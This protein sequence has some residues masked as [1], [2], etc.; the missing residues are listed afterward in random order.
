MTPKKVEYPSVREI[1]ITR[2]VD[3]PRE[4]V[5]KAWTTPENIAVWWGPRGFTTRVEEHDLRP[6]GR[7]H[8]VMVAPDGEEYPAM[9]TFREVVP[10]ERI[11]TTDEFGEDFEHDMDLP[12]G[13]VF[14]CL[15]EEV[16]EKTRLTLRIVHSD[17]ESRRKHE[18]MG[19]VEGWGSSLDCLE[20]HLVSLAGT[21][22]ELR[23]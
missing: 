16:G 14:D 20:E 18:E 6:G 8:Y 9:G 10:P 13:I 23:R 3:A 15:F 19:V 21:L 4:L 11:V 2:V 17:A 5:W 22:E 1:R 7:W 12:E